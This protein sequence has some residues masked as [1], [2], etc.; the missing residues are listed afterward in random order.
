MQT[1]TLNTKKVNFR[2]AEPE[3]YS[4]VSGLDEDTSYRPLTSEEFE[5]S[6]Y[7]R[8]LSIKIITY[9]KKRI[10]YFIVKLLKDKYTIL[11]IIIDVEYRRMGVGT[12]ILNLLKKK[13][14]KE[15]RYK[16]V[17]LVDERNLNAQL[18]LKSNEF[19]WTRTTEQVNCE[20]DM[21]CMTYSIFSTEDQL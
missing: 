10:G 1:Q 11:R 16:I 6:F 12:R 3:E 20:Y 4:F 5:A 2:T 17:A 9:E 18:F 14:T 13:L 19:K 8:R 15:Y 21:Y 7:T